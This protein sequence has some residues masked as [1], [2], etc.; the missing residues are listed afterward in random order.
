MLPERV[1]LSLTWISL[2]ENFHRSRYISCHSRKVITSHKNDLEKGRQPQKKANSRSAA[3]AG[4]LK[5]EGPQYP[6]FPSTV[7]DGEHCIASCWF[8]SFVTQ[9]VCNRCVGCYAEDSDARRAHFSSSEF[10]SGRLINNLAMINWTLSPGR[11]SLRW[12][13]FWHGCTAL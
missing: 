7:R 12:K 13:G 3:G 11:W 6:K 10:G 9:A 4:M 8:A 5:V 1:P 2:K